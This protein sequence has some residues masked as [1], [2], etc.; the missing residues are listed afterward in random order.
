MTSFN[1]W[2]KSLW[3]R[4]ETH[5]IIN[6]LGICGVNFSEES[7]VRS[8]TGQ[9]YVEQETR[10]HTQGDENNRNHRA[11]RSFRAP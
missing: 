2:V 10:H 3:R 5:Q 8:V 1:L 11:I 6:S 4:N 9:P 7:W